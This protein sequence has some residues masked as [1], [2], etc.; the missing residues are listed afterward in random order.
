[1]IL[2]PS[3]AQLYTMERE[4]GLLHAME[5]ASMQIDAY[6]V[7]QNSSPW[8]TRSCT[9]SSI[10]SVDMPLGSTPSLSLQCFYTCYSHWFGPTHRQHLRCSP[11]VFTKARMATI[12]TVLAVLLTAVSGYVIT[13]ALDVWP[14]WLYIFL[15]FAYTSACSNLMVYNGGMEFYKALASL[16]FGSAVIIAIVVADYRVGLKDCCV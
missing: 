14:S 8:S 12:V 5:L 1:M 10:S 6:W 3:V 7:A 4:D 2:L 9:R 13:N 11:A 15:P 16:F